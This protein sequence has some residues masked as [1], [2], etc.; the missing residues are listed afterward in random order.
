M[1]GVMRWV[2]NIALPLAHRHEKDEERMVTHLGEE[3]V[4][5]GP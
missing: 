5:G 2:D 3:A 4:P 1:H